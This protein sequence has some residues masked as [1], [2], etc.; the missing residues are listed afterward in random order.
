VI[1]AASNIRGWIES[2]HRDGFLVI[3]GVLNKD[4]CSEL[5][6]DLDAAHAESARR[7]KRKGLI[8]RMFEHSRAN[9]ELFWQEPIVTFAEQLIAD[10]GSDEVLAGESMPYSNGIPSANEVHVIHNNSFVIGSGR[11]GIGGSGWHQDDTPHVTSVDGQ[12][13]TGIRLNVLAVTCL[14][15]LTD[16]PTVKHGPTQAIQGSHLF[17]MHCTNER[18]ARYEDRI[19]S[20]TG[21]AGSAVIVNNQTWHRGAPNDSETDRYVTQV[22]YAKRLIGHKYGRFMNYQ[23]PEHVYRNVTDERKL[24][25]LG[26]LGHGAYG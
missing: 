4:V 26:F 6:A 2:F 23:M 24:R 3:P 8:K 22:T 10:N 9:L 17:G 18:A 20:G 15:Y 21:P 5:R 14:Y 25:L 12:P 11:K 19:L 1:P 13:L 16:V 7:G